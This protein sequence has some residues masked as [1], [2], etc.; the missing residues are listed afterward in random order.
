M[1]SSA[2]GGKGSFE[3]EGDGAIHRTPASGQ[4]EQVVKSATIWTSRG[5]HDAAAAWHAGCRLRVEGGDAI[6][7]DARSRLAHA[8][9]DHAWSPFATVL[10]GSRT[11]CRR[12]DGPLTRRM[13]R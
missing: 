13:Q 7:D 5:F 8:F 1:A 4:R 2:R 9:D 11:A 10:I 6:A 12:V 3:R